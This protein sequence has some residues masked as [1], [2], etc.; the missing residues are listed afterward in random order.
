[1]ISSNQTLPAE[2]LGWV[3]PEYKNRIL[4]VDYST[5]FVVMAFNGYRGGIF[6]DFMIQE[7]RQDFKTVFLVAHFN[8]VIPTGTSLP[9]FSSQYQ[10]VKIGR[11]QITQT[12][13]I[14]FKLLDETGNERATTTIEIN[15]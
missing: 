9:V 13:A 7:I 14:T 6:S 12:G 1:V 2:A 8:D 11:S 15:N 4:D 5:N 10:V 3:H